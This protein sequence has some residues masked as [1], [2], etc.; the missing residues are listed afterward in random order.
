MVNRLLVRALGKAGSR[1]HDQALGTIRGALA[2][3]GTP[4]PAL[5]D[6]HAATVDRCDTAWSEWLARPNTTACYNVYT[7][8]RVC[9]TGSPCYAYTDSGVYVVTKMQDRSDDK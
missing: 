5:S 4:P 3:M 2:T 1:L 6:D 7:A 9:I 8:V